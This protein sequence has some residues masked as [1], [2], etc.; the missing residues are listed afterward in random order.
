MMTIDIWSDVACPFCYI[1]KK[2]LEE[3]IQQS[4]LE[5]EIQIEWKSFQLD[6]EA[7]KEDD[8]SIYQILAEKY[9]QTEDHAR[10]MTKNVI[11]MAAQAGL[12]FNMDTVQ[13]TNTMDAHR[14]IHYAKSKGLQDTM[15]EILLNAY[16][17]RGLHLGKTETLIN[18]AEEAGLDKGDAFKILDKG[19]YAEDVQSDIEMAKKVGIQG[20]PFFLI[21]K[22]YGV[23]GAQPVENFSKVLDQIRR[24][25]VELVKE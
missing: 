25:K 9:D 7:P 14:M 10:S 6:P 8:R 23:S 16:F 20:V 18:L 13:P 1:G 21:N 4:G 12:D 5:D 2:H 3:A 22:K 11:A 17:V 15:K 24:E 19:K